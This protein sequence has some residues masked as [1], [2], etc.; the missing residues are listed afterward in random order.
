[1][2]QEQLL[3]KNVP[4]YSVVAGVPAQVIKYRF[5]KEKIDA[6]MKLNLSNL[7]EIYIK[8]HQELFTSELNDNILLKLENDLCENYN[9]S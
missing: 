5:S 9:E 8:K 1:M 6:L 3:Q 4:A 2:L 7:D